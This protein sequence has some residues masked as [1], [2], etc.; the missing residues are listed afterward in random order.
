MIAAARRY[1]AEL[2]SQ[3]D[4]QVA[5]VPSPQVSLPFEVQPVAAP[6]APETDEVRAR[7]TEVNPDALSPRQAHELLYDLKALL[8]RE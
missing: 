5:A 4:A 1:L 2:E 8:E 6:P 3:R 7:L